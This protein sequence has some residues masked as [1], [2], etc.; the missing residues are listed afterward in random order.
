MARVRRP[1]LSDAQKA[2]LW[3]RWRDGQSLT[4]IGRAVSKHAGSIH[5]VVS[6]RGGIVP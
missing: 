5:G 6:A 2:E 1:G 3:Q 4:E